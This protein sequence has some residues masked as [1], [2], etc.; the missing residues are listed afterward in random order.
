VKYGCLKIIGCGED[1]FKVDKHGSTWGS[2]NKGNTA[3]W[4]NSKLNRRAN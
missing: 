2:S 4:D 1:N 3:T